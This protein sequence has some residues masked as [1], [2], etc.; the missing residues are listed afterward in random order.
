M[1]R[2]GEGYVRGE[3]GHT[4]LRKIIEQK[5]KG[6]ENMIMIVKVSE[7]M[8]DPFPLPSPQFPSS[9]SPFCVTPLPIHQSL[10]R[11]SA[12]LSYPRDWQ[13]SEVVSVYGRR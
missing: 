3:R 8:G 9:P 6:I 7:S 4:E 13:G 11:P 10:L 1:R 2:E 5:R 12:T